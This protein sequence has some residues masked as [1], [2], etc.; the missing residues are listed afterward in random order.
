MPELVAPLAPVTTVPPA[1]PAPL[2]LEDCIHLAFEK[3]PALAGARASLAAALSGQAALDN[4]PIYARLCNPDLCVRKEQAAA[5]VTSAQ[6][7]LTQAEWETRY[8][9]TRNYYTVIYIRTQ[10][11]LLEEDIFRR[12]AEKRQ[13]AVDIVKEGLPKVK[14]TQLDVE[15]FDVYRDLFRARQAEANAGLQKALAALR[16]AIGIGCD[17][18]FEVAAGTLLPDSIAELNCDDLVKM[19]LANRGEITQANAAS[20]VVDLEI[21]AQARRCFSLKVGTFAGA[22]DIHAV[23]I[24]QGVANSEYRPGALGLEMPVVLIGRHGDR[25]ARA[26]DFSQ[27]AHA[28]VDKTQNLVVLEAESS[29]QKWLQA[30]KAIAIYR[31]AKPYVESVEKRAEER[32]A[33]HTTVDGTEYI[34]AL[35]LYYEVHANYNDAL[36]MHSLAVAALERIT[37]GGVRILPSKHP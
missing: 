28:V 5:G 7:A 36:Y 19:T 4:L 15:R 13:A 35:N 2:T 34:Y 10:L 21:E 29:Y 22:G 17:F 33:Q 20:R 30:K 14:I 23:A 12:L 9:V 1:P 32:F 18:P 31:S 27:R 3:Q 6:A 11:K 26:S 24:P 8:A 37:A 16:E 25:V